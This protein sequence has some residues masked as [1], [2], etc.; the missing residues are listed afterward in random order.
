MRPPAWLWLALSSTFLAPGATRPHYGGSLTVQL[1]AVPDPLEFPPGVAEPVA[2]TLVRFNVRGDIEPWLAASWQSEAE[3]KRWRFSLRTKVLFHDGQALNGPKAAQILLPAL[4]KKYPDVALTSGGQ[5]LVVQS[6]HAMPD[7]LA[8][9]AEPSA[10]LF[11]KGEG[12]AVVATGPFRVSGW[13]AGRKLTLSAFDD[14]WG[15]RPF[16]DSIT[17][18][19]G[20]S[21]AN[22]DL[23]DIPFSPTRRILPEGTT[24]WSSA[25]RELI[26]VVGN[27]DSA[28][29]LQALAF[30]IDRTPI[31]N[32]LTQRRGEPAFGLLPDWLSGYGFL[33]DARPDPA[34]ARQIVAQSKSAATLSYSTSDPF[35]RAIAERISLNARDGGIALQSTANPIGNLKLVRWA[36]ES[37]SPSQELERFADWLSAPQSALAGNNPQAFLEAEHALL[38]TNRVLP[39]VYLP[40]VYGAAPRVRNLDDGRHGAHFAIRLENLWIAP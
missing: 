28:S 29:V 24:I 25:P 26:A 30:V 12:G 8:A 32:V 37:P 4:R 17:I 7:L 34:R 21:R 16:L 27:G 9:L 2:E 33:F 19:A 11:E 40:V 20:D 36:I 6:E 35:L 22:T 31:V 15:G 13:D 38:A 3:A 1:A 18:I 5:T 39:I 10:A 14:Y 23:F